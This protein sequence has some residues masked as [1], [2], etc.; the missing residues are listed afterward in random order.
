MRRVIQT[1]FMIF[2]AT[3][4]QETANAAGEVIAARHIRAGTVVAR[5][6]LIGESDGE[7]FT[8][9]IGRETSRTI[10]KGA[11][12][13]PQDVQPRRFVKRNALVRIEFEK[14]P[15]LMSAE[16]RALE[17]GALGDVIRVMNVSS[18]TNLSVVVVGENRV[19]TP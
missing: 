18:R 2:A 1:G 19:Q 15:L 13:T 14:G 12:I 11:P 16:G 6:D 8:A 5:D 17:D 9:M 10:V 7:V 4:T 3:A